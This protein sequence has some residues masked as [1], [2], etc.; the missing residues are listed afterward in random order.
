MHEMNTIHK[1][2]LRGLLGVAVFL[3]LLLFALL[4]RIKAA[5]E[6]ARRSHCGGCMNQLGK[7]CVMYAMDHDGALPDKWSDITEPYG[8][9][10]LLDC[11]STPQPPGPI[12]TL[13]EWAEFVLVPGLT[14]NSMP[15]A[16]LAYEPLD[17]HNSRGGNVLFVNGAVEWMKPDQH[18]QALNTINKEHQ[19]Q[20]RR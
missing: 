6:A 5:R 9:P 17:N 13:D 7:M 15:N 20:R 16:V 14:T 1:A 8:N 12:D 3:T 2:F 10:R 4:P 19:H 18:A 11:T